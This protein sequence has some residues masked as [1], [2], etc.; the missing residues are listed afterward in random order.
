MMFTMYNSVY[1]LLETQLFIVNCM[2]CQEIQLVPTLQEGGVS[3]TGCAMPLQILEQV[4]HD[5]K[6]GK[7]VTIQNSNG[8]TLML[9]M[10]LTSIVYVCSTMLDS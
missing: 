6:R 10:N 4:I 5:Y 1:C 8:W 7:V 9:I 3:D 2:I